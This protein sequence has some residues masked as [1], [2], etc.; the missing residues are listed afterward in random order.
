[1]TAINHAMTGAVIGL[2]IHQPLLAIPLAFVSHFLM[3]ALPHYDPRV[4]E[5]ELFKSKRFRNYLISEASLCFLLVLV[6]AISQP[7][8]WLLACICAFVAAMPDLFSINR[9]WSVR[10]GKSW[11]GNA[12]SNFA[13]RIQRYAQPKGAL[14]EI[15]WGLVML[16]II[17]KHL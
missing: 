5:E 14:L 3:D 13:S 12:Y 2:S 4:P 9:F 17:A 6:L 1:M 16:S 7:T 15:V 11:R 8:N 10:Q